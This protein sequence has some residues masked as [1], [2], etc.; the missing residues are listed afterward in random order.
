MWMRREEDKKVDV[1]GGKM[2]SEKSG[3]RWKEWGSG[4]M[5]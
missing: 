3:Y 5:M 4:G 1:D 2:E